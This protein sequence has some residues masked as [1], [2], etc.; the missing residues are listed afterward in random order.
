LIEMAKKAMVSHGMWYGIPMLSTSKGMRF[1][2]KASA[3]AN[4]IGKKLAG[5][6]FGSRDAQVSAFKTAVSQCPGKNK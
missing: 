6:E 2:P 3:R 5:R 4:C 1:A